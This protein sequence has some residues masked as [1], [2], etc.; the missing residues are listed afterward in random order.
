MTRNETLVQFDATVDR[1]V[2]AEIASGR[3]RFAAIV[4][5]LPGVY[6][7]RVLGSLRRLRA[8]GHIAAQLLSDIE[9]EVTRR[10]V[11]TKRAIAD[12]LPLPHPLEY[13]WRFTANTALRLLGMATQL[14]ATGDSVLL[15]GTPSVAAMAAMY[16]SDRHVVFVGEDNAVTNSLRR[17]NG[18]ADSRVQILTCGEVDYAGDAAVVMLDPPWYFDFIRAM[19]AA[20]ALGCRLGGHLILSLSSI[21]TRPSAIDDRFRTTRLAER[22]GLEVIEERHSAL[23]YCSPLFERNALSAV[24]LTNVPNDWRRSDLML[25][26]KCRR[27]EIPAPPRTT[28]LRTWT[29]I[30]LGRVRVLTREGSVIERRA[31]ASLDPVAGGPVLP[32]VS[33]RDP[34]RREANVWTSGNRAFSCNRTD[35]LV[36]AAIEIGAEVNSAGSPRRARFIMQERE[37]I[38]RLAG[39][40]RQIA[41]TEAEESR[42]LDRGVPTWTHQ[43]RSNFQHCLTASETIRSGA[44]I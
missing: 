1:W 18:K 12:D 34:R 19:L 16:P 33:R 37:C 20:A 43:W 14:S 17:L 28:H 5:R 22:L 38:S 9:F 44:G 42:I 23:S 31:I 26:R 40:L 35:L 21:G 3:T 6:P 15:L 11:P 10:P 41:A 7:E 29:E 25:L 39:L 24:G 8:N 2:A 27:V 36:A 32:S 4:K 30:V 13:E